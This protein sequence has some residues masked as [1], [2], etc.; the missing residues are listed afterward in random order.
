MAT[1]SPSLRLPVHHQRLNLHAMECLLC[2]ALR[3]GLSSKS[4]CLEGLLAP[5]Q[6]AFAWTG[7]LKWLATKRVLTTANEPSTS[8]RPVFVL[9]VSIDRCNRMISSLECR[10]HAGTYIQ[11]AFNNTRSRAPFGRICLRTYRLASL[12]LMLLSP[13]TVSA[14]CVY[15]SIY[16][17]GVL[18][19]YRLAS[20]FLML[21][22]PRSVRAACVYTSI[23]A[24]G[25]LFT[26]RLA[27]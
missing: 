15:A 2:F 13:R 3:S 12:F 19:T 11:A 6:F 16:A 26:D 9:S 25:V 7:S 8:A 27:S 24:L 14:A 10:H 18:F 22:S 23:Y 4:F 5:Y 17:L 20:F 1:A 21:F